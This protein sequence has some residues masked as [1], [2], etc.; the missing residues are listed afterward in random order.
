MQ[1]KH[2]TP[3]ALSLSL[4]LSLLAVLFLFI[5]LQAGKLQ[6]D[7]KCTHT[8]VHSLAVLRAARP[9]LSLLLVTRSAVG[10]EEEDIQPAALGGNW[11]RTITYHP[12]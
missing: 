1:R 10:E 9:L 4:S 3:S 5:L 8:Q 6:R 11:K 7:K 12:H 2:S